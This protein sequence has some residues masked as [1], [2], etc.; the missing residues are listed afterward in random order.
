M[1][2]D[3]HGHLSAPAE[4]WAYKASL[5]AHNGA[6]GHTRLRVSDDQLGAALTEPRG[7]R[8]GHIES[9]KRNGV[10]LQLISPPQTSTMNSQRPTKLVHWYTAETN[11]L[12]HRTVRLF[13]DTFLG[14]CGLPQAGDE[15]IERSLPE[16]A[17]CI[18][19]G[20][21]GCSITPDPYENS[22]PQAPSMGDRYWYPLYEKLCE[23]DIPG[24]IHPGA[25]RSE[26][27]TYQVHCSNEETI[28]VFSL[29]TSSVFEDFPDLKLIVAH[30]GGAIPYQLG[31]F[32]PWYQTLFPDR[33][34]LRQ[35]LRNLYFDTM[36]YSPDSLEL[37]LKTIGPERTVYG[38]ECPGVG[39]IGNPRTGRPYDDLL[40]ALRDVPFLDQRQISAITEHTAR[41]LFKI[42]PY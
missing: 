35:A 12:I 1:L 22:G 42:E 25:S 20:F 31:R 36:V 9:I 41:Q 27:T 28:A 24:Y 17:R 10:D 8:P 18:G 16:L 32:E 38:T 37:L 5:Q 3:V 14:V 19:N 7:N 34:P 23:Y 13:P 39:S 21:C 15:P 30:G 11:D 33:P 2:I 4:L 29:V 6:H 40:P 26:R